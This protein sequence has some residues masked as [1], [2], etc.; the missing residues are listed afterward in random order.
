MK[1]HIPII[2]MLCM[3]MPL[4][5]S[6]DLSIEE[7]IRVEIVPL[8]NRP[9]Q[10][11]FQSIR[12]PNIIRS[13]SNSGIT[14]FRANQDIIKIISSVDGMI[15]SYSTLLVHHDFV[16]SDVLRHNV[17]FMQK[18][19]PEL[20]ICGFNYKAIIAVHGCFGHN[21]FKMGELYRSSPLSCIRFPINESIYSA[22]DAD[23]RFETTEYVYYITKLDPV[24]NVTIQELQID[25]FIP[26][27]PLLLN[28]SVGFVESS[29][30]PSS[31]FENKFQQ[32]TDS[33][34]FQNM[35]LNISS[36]FP[37][38]HKFHADDFFVEEPAI[39][40]IGEWMLD[41]EPL[42]YDYVYLEPHPVD[43]GGGIDIPDPIDEVIFI[44]VVILFPC[45]FISSLLYYLYSIYN[46]KEKTISLSNCDSLQE[47]VEH[48]KRKLRIKKIKQTEEDIEK[49]ESKIREKCE[50]WNR[51]YQEM[52][53]LYNS[54]MGLAEV[55]RTRGMIVEYV[56]VSAGIELIKDVDI[57]S[58]YSLV[59]RHD[60]IVDYYESETDQKKHIHYCAKFQSDFYRT[61]V[62]YD[63]V[64][65]AA[66]VVSMNKTR[67]D[68]LKQLDELQGGKSNDLALGF[69][70]V[71]TMYI[72]IEIGFWIQGAL[73]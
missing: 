19:V 26:S 48:Q 40:M 72:I 25:P 15:T 63:I 36:T 67:T 18:V 70:I 53:T 34:T 6:A 57:L 3:M 46:R 5:V 73:T 58:F 28:M 44:P 59:K 4:S 69:I 47:Y 37:I 32:L 56:Q 14:R 31:L 52:K 1:R 54:I 24:R 35:T 51:S 12:N 39:P 2:L 16:E 71:F 65:D 20:E 43:G 45:L 9:V 13:R 68:L 17:S 49:A 61:Q 29:S 41:G 11:N 42:N 27:D 21:D 22:F 66:Y 50:I 10:Y 33:F 60:L 55:L 8:T 23:Y 62:D 30:I 64:T 38:V 7:A